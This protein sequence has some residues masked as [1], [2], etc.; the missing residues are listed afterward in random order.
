MKPPGHDFYA[1]VA[2]LI[3]LLLVTAAV[4]G[5]RLGED[6]EDEEPLSM[7]VLSLSVGGEIAALAGLTGDGGAIA[8]SLASFGVG[9]LATGVVSP[10]ALRVLP[11]KSVGRWRRVP[12]LIIGLV[13]VMAPVAAAITYVVRLTI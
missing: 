8:A 9:L 6:A 4:D 7:A 10:I 5:R 11:P 2:A 1:A 3:P 12:S 13:T